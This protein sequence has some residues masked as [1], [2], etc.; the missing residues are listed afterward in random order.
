MP[1]LACTQSEVGAG[2]D[3]TITGTI[4]TPG[5]NP[6]VAGTE[7]GLL[8]VA[9]LGE[10]LVGGV[11]AAG[12]FGAVC[13]VDEPPAVC[14]DALRTTTGDSGGFRLEIKGRDT[15][16]SLGQASDLDL[17]A[18]VESPEGPRLVSVRFKAQQAAI[19]LPILSA[20][21]ASLALGGL[22][23]TWSELD[24]IYPDPTYT[25]RFLDRDGR[26][27]WAVDDATSGEPVDPRLVED[28]SGTAELSAETEQD[29]EGTAFRITHFA[30]PA[31]FSA[32]QAPPS[33]G[34]PCT[35][36]AADGSG[37]LSLAPCHLTDGDLTT[38]RSL[39]EDG[40]VRSAAAVDLGRA[41]TVDLVVARGAIGPVTVET[42]V[43][44]VT[45]TFAGTSTGSLVAVTPPRPVDARYVRIRTTGGTDLSSLAELSV[46]TA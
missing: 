30:L 34:L 18:V 14:D 11:L 8:K 21:F 12:T 6:G 46:W 44:G 31:T 7:I 36:T 3:L 45:W 17:T 38:A 10:L 23:P 33:R 32:S 15:Q 2:E 25:V 13:L 35:A 19:D 1:L 24:P 9:D 4:S 5:G 27:V 39:S 26:S 29:W 20:W 28:A 16:G 41:R 42:S 43:D 22:T 37:A 40:T